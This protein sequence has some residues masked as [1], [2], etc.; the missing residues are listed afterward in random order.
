VKGTTATTVVYD[1]TLIEQG[2]EPRAWCL[3]G[4]AAKGVGHREQL[5]A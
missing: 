5:D 4:S 3:A 2:L 1:S